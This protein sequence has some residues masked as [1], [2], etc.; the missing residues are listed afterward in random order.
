MRATQLLPVMARSTLRTWNPALFACVSWRLS[1]L[2]G[3]RLLQIGQ[4]ILTPIKTCANTLI[5]KQMKSRDGISGIELSSPF[6]RSAA[7]H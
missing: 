5:N 6:V 4:S 7:V 2:S 3:T 1:Y